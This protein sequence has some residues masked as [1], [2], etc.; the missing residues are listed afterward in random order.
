MDDEKDSAEH[1]R[2]RR[3]GRGEGGL[4]GS[5]YGMGFIGAAIYFIQH[6]ESFWGGVFG[7]IKAIFWPAVLMYELLKLMKL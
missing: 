4:F 3:R 6:A 7:F 5:M 2:H 1:S